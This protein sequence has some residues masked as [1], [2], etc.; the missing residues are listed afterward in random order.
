MFNRP[1]KKLYQSIIKTK[2]GHEHLDD[3]KYSQ[4]FNDFRGKVK[5]AFGGFTSLIAATIV[6]KR[7]LVPF[8]ATPLAGKVE[9]KMAQMSDPK[10]TNK[11]EEAKT[12]NNSTPAMKGSLPQEVPA[13]EEVKENTNTNLLDKYKK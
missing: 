6:G 3:I 1:V 8:I 7:M 9:K 10:T 2:P 11:P 13:V 4:D 5:D 12:E